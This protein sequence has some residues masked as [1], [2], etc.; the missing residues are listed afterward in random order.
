[1]QTIS[2]KNLILLNILL[3]VFVVPSSISGTA[4]ALP[5]IARDLG[6]N[7]TLLQ[8]VVNAFNLFF[9]AFTLI[10]GSLSDRFGATKALKFGIS[11]FLLG[12]LLSSLANSLALLDIARAIAGIGGASVFACGSAILIKSFEE[13]ERLK[14]FALFGTTAGLGITLG[15]TLSGFLIDS[16]SGLSVDSTPISWRAIFILHFLIL[17]L[18]L[19]L[20]KVLPQE[21]RKNLSKS[22]IDYSGAGLFV[23]CI[24][25]FMLS[26]TRLSSLDSMTLA[27]FLIS[28]V[29]A[30]A[31]VL[32]QRHLHSL[33]RTPLLDFALLKNKAFFGF[34]LVAVVSGF[35][36]VVLLTY[37]PTFLQVIFGFSASLSGLFMLSLTTPMLFC[38]ALVGKLLAKGI[39][40]RLL[41]LAMS[42]MMSVGI[43]A[44]LASIFL[45]SKFCI[46]ISLF[47]IGSGMGLHAGGIDNLALSSL[48]GENVG[49]GAGLLN[50][51]RLGSESIGVALY[52]SL[53][54]VF[55]AM[56]G[57]TDSHTRA[58]ASGNIA[59]LKDISKEILANIYQESFVYTLTICGILCLVLS[60]FVWGL[61]KKYK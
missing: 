14:A 46:I 15:P 1:M 41:A 18:V 9:A 2:H 44:L 58:L 25:C 42:L 13:K 21:D 8:W 20:S 52:A 33:G 56:A 17:A 4:I 24:F 55:I 5:Y 32:Q 61:L 43:F 3:A 57:L 45:E 12:S 60:F 26:I 50:T 29:S 19:L 38:P 39:D 22:H 37:F 48:K 16:F 31:L 27:I 51:L 40:S 49:L 10:W 47:L 23:L 30:V 53:M 7:P 35:S 11:L 36:F 54:V 34:S 59:S 6:D 28:L